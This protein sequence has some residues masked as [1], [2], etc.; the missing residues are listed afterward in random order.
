MSPQWDAGFGGGTGVV[1]TL[2]RTSRLLILDPFGLPE[3][4]VDQITGSVELLRPSAGR[5]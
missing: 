3:G 2:M 1:C 4:R 5:K